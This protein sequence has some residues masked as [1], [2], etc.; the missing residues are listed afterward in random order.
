MRARDALEVVLVIDTS[1][2][3]LYGDEDTSRL[4]QAVDS[5]TESALP[6]LG[7]QFAV[8]EVMGVKFKGLPAA[9][10]ARGVEVV[11]ADEVDD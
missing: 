1:G 4:Q 9:L 5:L 11:A 8:N 2:S 7:S 10:F 3:M 6:A